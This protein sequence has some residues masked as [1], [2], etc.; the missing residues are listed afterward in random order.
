MWELSKGWY[1]DRLEP[2]YRPKPVEE[3]QAVLSGVGLTSPF[4]QLR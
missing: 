4:W 1:G 3:L 2:D